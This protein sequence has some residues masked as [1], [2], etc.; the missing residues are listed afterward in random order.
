[1]AVLRY[2][3]FLNDSDW[4]SVYLSFFFAAILLCYIV[5]IIY[6]TCWRSKQLVVKA[7]ASRLEEIEELENQIE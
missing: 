6:F 2:S 5:F 1:M 7:K 4:T 3:D